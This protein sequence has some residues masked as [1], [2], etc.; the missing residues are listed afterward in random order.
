LT[1]PES[2]GFVRQ[3][4]DAF[5]S[6]DTGQAV[7][8]LDANG[9]VRG[10]PRTSEVMLGWTAEQA[11]GQSISVIFT[12]EDRDRK[13]DVFELEVARASGHAEDDRWHVRRDDSRVW[14]TGTLTCIRNADGSV[15]GFVK[16]MRDRTDL[17]AKIERHEAELD[18]LQQQ[19]QRSQLFLDTLGHELRNPLGPLSMAVHLLGTRETAPASTQALQVI[20]RQIAVLSGLAE[21]LMDLARAHHDGFQ[22]VLERVHV[23]QLLED[24]LNDLQPAAQAKGIVLRAVLQQGPIELQADRRRLTQVVLNLLGN[25]LKYTPSGGTVFLKAGEEVNEV[26]IRVEDSG[27]GI[28]AEMLPRIFEFF[29]QDAGAKKLAPGG[30]GVGLGLVRQIVELHGGT[31]A[32]RS[33]GQGLGSEF[34]V[35][36]PLQRS[37]PTTLPAPL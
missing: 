15:L 1:H 6:G 34:T 4:L 37:T 21:D 30:L 18:K 28:G 29:A 13:I 7:I 22:L 26:V 33:P 36:L 11:I 10:W 5:M 24:A 3:V 19:L 12:P 16:A 17:R 35:R 14:V 32:A 9:I 2:P 23:Q 25:A 31:A 27:I 20:R 8:V